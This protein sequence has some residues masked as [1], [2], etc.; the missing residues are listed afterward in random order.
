MGMGLVRS[1]RGSCL[2]LGAL[3]IGGKSE[4]VGSR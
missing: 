4:S 3:C 2:G 1:R